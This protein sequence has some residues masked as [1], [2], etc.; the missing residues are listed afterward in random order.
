MLKWLVGGPEVTSLLKD[1]D[2]DLFYCLPIID[3]LFSEDEVE[4]THLHH[5][6]EKKR[7]RKNVTQLYEELK[8]RGN[9]FIEDG[10]ELKNINSKCIVSL[11]SSS[12]VRNALNIGLQAHDEFYEERLLSG[13]LSIYDT[14]F[15]NK[16]PLISSDKYIV[17]TE[18]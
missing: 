7:F 17:N 15:L 6:S 18:K 1:I 13:K 8:S 4:D 2:D 3:D 11:A 16:L 10:E 5:D 12:S 9:L 14:I